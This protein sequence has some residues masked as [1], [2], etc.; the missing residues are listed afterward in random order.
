MPFIRYRCCPKC[1]G[2]VEKETSETP[3]PPREVHAVLITVDVGP[4]VTKEFDVGYKLKERC[5]VQ[6]Y[7]P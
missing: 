4:D 7:Q 6:H 5:P 3:F 2:I 1:K